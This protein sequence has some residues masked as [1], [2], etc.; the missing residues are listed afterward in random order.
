[1]MAGAAP[2]SPNR[3]SAIRACARTRGEGS[4]RAARNGAASTPS[5]SVLRSASAR[6]ANS[7]TASS[8]DELAQD[9]VGGGAVELLEREEGR[10]AP[11]QGPGRVG[12][13]IGEG[14]V[15]SGDGPRRRISRWQWKRE[16]AFG[17]HKPSISSASASPFGSTGEV[18]LQ[19]GGATHARKPTCGPT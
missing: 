15:V 17:P 18:G 1:M 5:S 7:R 3:P 6:S 11:V 9:A 12:R 14:R 19:P 13:E 2:T 16:A 8:A 4:A 10:D